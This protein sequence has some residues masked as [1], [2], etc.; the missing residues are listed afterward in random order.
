MGELCFF[1]KITILKIFGT[2]KKSIV[3]KTEM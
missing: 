3:D 2:Q 1:S